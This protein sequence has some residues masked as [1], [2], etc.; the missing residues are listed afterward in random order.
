MKA[1]NPIETE[2]ELAQLLFN[3]SGAESFELQ[4]FTKGSHYPNC[5]IKFY[6]ITEDQAE[7]LT[8]MAKY[9][10]PAWSEVVCMS[11]TKIEE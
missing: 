8:Y 2:L 4:L 9:I 6:G 3:C 5:L 1:F 7:A 10:V 11:A